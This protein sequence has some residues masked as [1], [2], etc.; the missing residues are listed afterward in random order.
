MSAVEFG[1]AR[2]EALWVNLMATCCRKPA[3]CFILALRNS[4]EILI[5]DSS[6]IVVGLPI[7]FLVPFRVGTT[8]SVGVDV[9]GV[10]SIR[11]RR[12]IQRTLQ[13][14]P[15]SSGSLVGR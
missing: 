7:Q 8:R 10:W 15:V 11:R 12:A 5:L 6:A 1:M 13:G 14:V 2:S 4:F 3:S 9:K